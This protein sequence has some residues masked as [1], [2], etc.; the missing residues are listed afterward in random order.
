MRGRCQVGGRFSPRR[1]AVKWSP[2][3]RCLAWLVARG[4]DPPTSTDTQ[5]SPV[6]LLCIVVLL[7]SWV[8]E[9]GAAPALLRAGQRALLHGCLVNGGIKGFG[10]ASNRRSRMSPAGQPR[11]QGRRSSCRTY[12][13]GVHAVL[14]GCHL[15]SRRSFRFD[16][17]GPWTDP[18]ASQNPAGDGHHRVQLCRRG[19]TWLERG[20]GETASG[21]QIQLGRDCPASC[22]QP[23]QGQG[24]SAWIDRERGDWA[25]RTEYPSRSDGGANTEIALGA[26]VERRALRPSVQIMPGD[27]A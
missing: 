13:G 7:R 2:Q 14:L 6:V 26:M 5:P 8:G 22:R 16:R 23:W 17:R 3:R 27:A 9:S 4:V 10:C 18:A 15:S 1:G 20:G 25:R 11:T 24:L 19:C 12:S 21:A